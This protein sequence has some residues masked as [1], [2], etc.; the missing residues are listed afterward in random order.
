MR[1]YVCASL[2]VALAV[3]LTGCGG[4]KSSSNGGASNGGA[5]SS[6]QYS[7]FRLGELMWQGAASIKTNG[8]IQTGEMESLV[9]QN[10][11]EVGPNGQPKLG[12]A[13]SVEHP[14]AT[15]YIYHLRSG[16]KFSDGTPLTVADA[17]YSLALNKNALALTSSEAWQVVASVSA[18]GDS[19]VMVKLK[20][21]SADWQNI[22][23][24]S[25]QVIEKAAAE[26]A[27]GLKTLGTPQGL[28][29]GTGP[30][31]FDSYTPEVSVQFS[32]NPYWAGQPQPAKKISVT[33]FKSEATMALA[34]RSG[35]IDAAAAYAQPKLFASIPG[36]HELGGQQDITAW[37][38]MRTTMPPFNDVHVRRAVAYATEVNG[39]IKA[40]Y[41][42]GNASPAQSV[43]ASPLFDGLGSPSQVSTMLAAV[44]TYQFNLTKAKQEL[45]KSA[46]PHGFTTYISYYVSETLLLDIAQTVAAD[47]SKIG[48]TVKIKALQ[49]D[50]L[51]LATEAKDPLVMNEFFSFTPNAADSGMAT[52]LA[53]K[54]PLN[55]EWADS[56][57][58][59]L[60]KLLSEA[61]YTINPSRRLQLMQRALEVEAAE[62]PYLIFFQHKVFVSLSNKYA[63]PYFSYYPSEYSPWMLNMKLAQ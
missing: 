60:G 30:W 56:K 61:T 11:V 7:D 9:V 31:K 36:T 35:A 4:S 42:G 55:E 3:A 40:I 62:E 29:I 23:A 27:G 8:W 16:V 53:P 14:N 24:G 1:K 33:L 54:A 13:R 59:E 6:K 10:L 38:S 63:D 17:V 26:K 52:L 58:P 44:P 49:S 22:M 50:E 21:P 41:P 37:M 47:L 25:S 34:L 46:Y 43:A 20:R 32:R 5:G 15:T 19:A 2:A 51:S 57:N 45:A 48:I 39:L 12:L 18:D 28:P